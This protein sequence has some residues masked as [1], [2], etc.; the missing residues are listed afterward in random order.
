MKRITTIILSLVFAGISAQKSKT[1]FTS[2]IDNFWNAYDQIKKT[3]DF[4]QKLS[5]IN[6][7][8]LIKVPQ[9]L[10]HL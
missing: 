2:D 7:L 8:Y 4:S 3:D 9:G 5:L 6:T 1:I 10:R